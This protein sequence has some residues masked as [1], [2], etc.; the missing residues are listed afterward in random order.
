MSDAINATYHE[1]KEEYIW[2]SNIC[3]CVQQIHFDIYIVYHGC[4]TNTCFFFFPKA[5]F[6]HWYRDDSDE[7][8]VG[9]NVEDVVEDNNVSPVTYDLFS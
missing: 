8:V 2:F 3:L 7:K 6:S 4:S 1:D 5:N 9:G